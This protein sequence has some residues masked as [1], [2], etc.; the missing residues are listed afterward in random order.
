MFVLQKFWCTK[1]TLII[2]IYP[3]KCKHFVDIFKSFIGIIY[4]ITVYGLILLIQT[5][6]SYFLKLDVSSFTSPLEI[7]AVS[8]SIF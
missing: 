7:I 1:F 2:V 8:E 5:F 3:G 4:D 6:K